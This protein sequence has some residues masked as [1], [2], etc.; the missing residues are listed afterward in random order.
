M[1]NILSISIMLGITMIL[2]LMTICI[3]NSL[4]IVYKVNIDF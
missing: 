3:Y 2:L 1:F 4:E